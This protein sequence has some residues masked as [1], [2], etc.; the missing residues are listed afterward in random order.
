[1]LS[2]ETV[3]QA[4]PASAVPKLLIDF[5]VEGLSLFL[6]YRNYS[7]DILTGAKVTFSP[8]LVGHAGQKVLSELPLFQYIPLLVPG[9]RFVLYVDELQRFFARYENPRFRIHLQFQN[10]Q[11]Q[12]FQR[13]IIHDLTI[14]KD[15][16][17]PLK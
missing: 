11:G 1:M 14:Y 8:K 17:Q 4:E 5:Y 16:P 7:P 10:E 12:R 13:S 15:Y 9:K 3:M 6:E 2:T